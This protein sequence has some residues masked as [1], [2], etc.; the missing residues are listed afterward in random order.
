MGPLAAN[1][2]SAL[3]VRA[4]V[5]SKID[6]LRRLL[7]SKDRVEL[8]D[9]A[10]DDKYRLEFA[11][12][13][14]STARLLSTLFA[15]Y[16]AVP[17]PAD[18]VVDLPSGFQLAKMWLLGRGQQPFTGGGERDRALEVASMDVLDGRMDLAH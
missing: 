3:Q 18:D 17:Q 6:H 9:C 4:S 13:D 15:S 16:L 12:P 1:G 8:R 14:G 11:D 5:N 2:S 10:I 7:I